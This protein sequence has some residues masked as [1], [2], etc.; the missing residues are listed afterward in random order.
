LKIGID[1][2]IVDLLS[3]LG[4]Q[5]TIL[6]LSWIH[7]LILTLQ[8]VSKFS[9]YQAVDSIEMDWSLGIFFEDCLDQGISS[10]LRKLRKK[11][12]LELFA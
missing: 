2:R 1:L 4:E 9:V 5:L 12:Q 8:N 7:P 11:Y 6:G 10:G 3:S